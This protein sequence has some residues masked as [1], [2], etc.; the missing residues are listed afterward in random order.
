MRVRPTNSKEYKLGAKTIVHP[1]D[2]KVKLGGVSQL[3]EYDLGM[4]ILLVEGRQSKHLALLNKNQM[5][6]VAYSHY[7]PFL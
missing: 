5:T 3:D 6:R 4:K 7:F 1:V 2:D